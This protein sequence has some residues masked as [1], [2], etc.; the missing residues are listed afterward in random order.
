[1]AEILWHGMLAM[2]LV[3]RRAKRTGDNLLDK[4]LLFWMMQGN[5]RDA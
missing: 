4:A 3:L 5:A 1:L 2:E